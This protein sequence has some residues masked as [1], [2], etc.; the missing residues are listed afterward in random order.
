MERVQFKDILDEINREDLEN[1]KFMA[2]MEKKT[3]HKNSSF[4]CRK[5]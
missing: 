3:F 4:N 5:T 1:L 2:K